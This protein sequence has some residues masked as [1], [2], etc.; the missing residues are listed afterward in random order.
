[1]DLYDMTLTINNALDGMAKFI[2]PIFLVPRRAGFEKRFT[3][4]RLPLVPP[5]RNSRESF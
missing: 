5:S 3:G 1:M 2:S 4:L